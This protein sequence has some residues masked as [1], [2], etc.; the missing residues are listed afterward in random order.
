MGGVIETLEMAA[1]ALGII[2]AGLMLIFL[3]AA[4]VFFFGRVSDGVEGRHDSAA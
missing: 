2:W 1:L 3:I 4:L